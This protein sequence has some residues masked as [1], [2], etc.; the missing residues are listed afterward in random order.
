MSTPMNLDIFRAI[1]G[2]YEELESHEPGIICD[3]LVDLFIKRHT[4]R[5]YGEPLTAQRADRAIGIVA[6]AMA[7]AE[8]TTEEEI[9]EIHYSAA[10]LE[11]LKNA[12]LEEL[13]EKRDVLLEMLFEQPIKN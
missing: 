1:A 5:K 3:L 13:E 12:T 4:A 11:A 2:R 10:G 8:G 9:R 7:E 6:R